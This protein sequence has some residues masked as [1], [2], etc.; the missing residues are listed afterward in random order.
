MAFL[1]VEGDRQIYFEHHGAGLKGLP[2]LLV[3]GWG[4][5]VRVWDTTVPALLAGGHPVIAY[6]QRGCGKSD[7][8]FTEISVASSGRDAAAL[9][10]HLGIGR[11]A[12]N[13]WS[14]GGAVSVEAAGLL[15]PVCAGLVLTA[16]ATPRYVAAPDFPF[17]P[18]V[19]TVAQTVAAL[20]AD[21]ASFFDGLS[22]VVCAKPVSAALVTWMWSI[23]ME[24]SPNADR[25]L[26]DLDHLDQRE[27]LAKL[28]VPVLSTVG[29]LD[30][31]VAPDIGRQ[32]PR[33]ARNC[34][35]VEFADCGHAPFIEDGPR[36]REVLLRFL[37][38]LG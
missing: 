30:V 20:Q 34:E 12:V 4:M 22:K 33:Y 37:K 6:D 31:F 23:F 5:S 29:A 19:G 18:P 3:H 14:L 25:A 27:A 9:L 2:I 10:R 7:K 11:A 21:R 38:Q 36:Y 28:T 24:T 17:G 8:D 26:A 13:G 1:K 15:G 35:V 16:G 32:V